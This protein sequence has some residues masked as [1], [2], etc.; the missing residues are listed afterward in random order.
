MGYLPNSRYTNA[1]QELT[2]ILNNCLQNLKVAL[3]ILGRKFYK[4][5]KN[6][7]LD[8]QSRLIFIHKTQVVESHPTREIRYLLRPYLLRSRSIPTANTVYLHEQLAHLHTE[9]TQ[10]KLQ[11]QRLMKTLWKIITCLLS[12]RM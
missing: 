1:E 4:N 10:A 12:C 3:Q 11:T 2:G 5:T 6:S 8:S 7:S 9:N